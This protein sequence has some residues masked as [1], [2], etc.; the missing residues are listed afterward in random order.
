MTALLMFI[1]YPTSIITRPYYGA[2]SDFIFLI[3]VLHPT[4][5]WQSENPRTAPIHDC[6]YEFKVRGGVARVYRGVVMMTN[7]A[8]PI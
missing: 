1:S 2:V 3:Q 7:A 4:F 8:L 5:T 6:R